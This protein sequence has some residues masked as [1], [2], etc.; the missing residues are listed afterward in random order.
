MGTYCRGTKEDLDELIDL[1]NMV[2]SMSSGSV[3][4]EKLLPKAY[5]T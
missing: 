5:S 2:F 4:F 1:A 3:D